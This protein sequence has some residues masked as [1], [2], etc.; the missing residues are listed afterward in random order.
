MRL[1]RL[2]LSALLALAACEASPS[3]PERFYV[4]L[5]RGDAVVALD[6]R[7][8]KVVARFAPGR[9]PRGL[10][11]SPDGRTL[12]IAVSGS[13]IVG[14][15]VD[16]D[17]QP[18][19]DRRA[20][21]IAVIDLT[22]GKLDRV[23]SAGTDP[24]SFAVSPDGRTL[25][26]SNEDGG[27]V[28]EVAVDGTRPPKSGTVGDQPEGVAVTRDGATLFVACEGSDWV[29]MLD[30][31]TMRL[32][33]TIPVAGRPRTLLLS[34]DGKTVFVAAEFGGRLALLSAETGALYA[35][36]DLRRGDASLRPMG[37]VEATDRRLFVTTGR[38][39]AVLEVDPKRHA[40]V[41]RIDGIGARP[42]GIA[43]D[44]DG[45]L[46]ATANGPSND[47][48]FVDRAS[49]KAVSR[50]V[51]GAGPWGIVGS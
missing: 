21:G 40:V 32:R 25:Y 42:W 20:D 34:R 18:L 31:R 9:R 36:I 47:V 8:G 15:G 24:E 7:S 41:G 28:S 17:R 4:S 11:L 3:P 39:G 29:A 44:R 2:L 37:M 6:P 16:D 26:V 5:E 49:G 14:P 27:A 33:R 45:R 51:V 10:H 12:F 50:V 1:R 19:P 43:I 22:S 23:L 48:T 46:L 35:Q 30:A 13:A 38:G